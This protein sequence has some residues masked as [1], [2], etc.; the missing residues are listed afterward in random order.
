MRCPLDKKWPAKLRAVMTE[1]WAG[2]PAAR[3][4]CRAVTEVLKTL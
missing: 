2:D 3:P 4:D 1:G